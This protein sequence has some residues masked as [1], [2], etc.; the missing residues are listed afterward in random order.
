VARSDRDAAGYAID[1]E[2]IGIETDYIARH[3]GRESDIDH[4]RQFA[5]SFVIRYDSCSFGETFDSI[6]ID[7]ARYIR[8]VSR[9]VLELVDLD[10]DLERPAIDEDVWPIAAARLADRF[11]ILDI[12]DS[13][14]IDVGDIVL[15]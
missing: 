2:R 14:I 9:A 1:L 4:S 13:N 6:I 7:L 10:N 5:R 12:V 11:I 3:A 15:Q 8:D